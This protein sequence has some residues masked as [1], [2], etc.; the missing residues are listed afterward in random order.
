MVQ[1]D[2]TVKI[3]SF[4]TSMMGAHAAQSQGAAPEVLH[5]MSPK[6]LR[7]DPLDSRSNFFSLAAILY[8]MVTERRAFQGND[9]KQVRQSILEMTPE[10]PDQHNPKM[11]PAV[12]EVI[13]TS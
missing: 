12:S 7:G 5:Y 8:E 11:H 6:Q 9:A 2:G 10:A 4:G 3:L 13:T 1:W